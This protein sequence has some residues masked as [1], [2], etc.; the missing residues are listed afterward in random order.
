M[1]A[2][3]CKLRPLSGLQDC[4]GKASQGALGTKVA[5]I[6][7]RGVGWSMLVHVWVAR[8]VIGLEANVLKR[9]GHR[10]M[11][12]LVVGTKNDPLLF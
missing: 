9:V 8:N 4:R 3:V 6:R 10:G 11:L 2:G 1:L 5:E 7:T 12:S